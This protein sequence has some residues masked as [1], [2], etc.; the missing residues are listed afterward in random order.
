MNTACKAL[1]VSTWVVMAAALVLLFS[2]SASAGL[3]AADATPTSVTLNWTAPGDDSLSGQASAY[4][5]RYSLSTIT[6]ANWASATKV[7]GLPAP[8]VAGSAESFEVTALAS[9]TTY[10]FALKVGDEV[11]NW[12]ALSN[13]IQKS[14]LQE[15]TAPAAIADLAAGTVTSATVALTWTAPGD[16]GSTGTATT[17]DIRYSTSAITS[18]NWASATQVTGETAPKVAGS[19][20]TFTVSGLSPSTTYYFAIE[21]A[22]EVPNWSTLSNVANKATSAETTPP[23]AIANL[24]ASNET[25]TSVTLSWTAPGDDG[26]VGTAAQYDVRYSTATITAAN[27]SSATRVTTA[28][29]PKTAGSTE[30]FI[31]TGLGSNTTYYFAVKTADEVPNWSSI[32][33]VVNRTTLVEQTPPAAITNLAASSSGQTTVTLTWTSPGDDSLTGTATTYDIRYST[34][35][36]TAGNWSSATQVTGETAPKVAG[37][38]ETIS[39][40]GLSMSTTYYF[41]IKT[42][43]EVPNWSGLSNVVSKATTGDITPPASVKDL[44]ALPGTKDGDLVIH[45]TAPGDDS[46]SGLATIYII[47]YSTS[48]ITDANFNSAT[49]VM[50]PPLPLVAGSSQSLTLSGLIPGGTY[51]VALKGVDEKSNIAGISN[52]AQGQ[53]RLIIGTGTNDQIADLV[54]PP[55]NAVVPTAHPTLSVRAIGLTTADSYVFEVATD[56]SFFGMVASAVVP[57]GTDSIITW[58]IPIGLDP[59]EHYYWRTHVDAYAYSPVGTFSVVPKAHPYPNP[60]R[61]SSNPTATFT[62]LPAGSELILLTISGEPIRHWTGLTGT[63]VTWDGTNE[64]G[65]PVASGTYLWYVGDAQMSGKLVVIR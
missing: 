5:I 59:N 14:T 6:E 40:T 34:S 61:P 38:S 29:T 1:P 35:A 42:A 16:D 45:W 51:Y 2:S 56:S 48:L 30:S 10:Y 15:T 62:D 43:D 7:T 39:I 33:N 22:D 3:M 32:S 50:N 4:D 28:P 19:A 55:P 27:F 46:V 41:A 9:N 18:A 53:A 23:S 58:R 37:S 49:L 44:T 52:V 12:S 54:S 21:T 31:V 25:S 57:A 60:Y 63:D 64:S 26:S 17:Y 20:E 13:V 47:R 24:G 65:R 36:I 8:K 11:P